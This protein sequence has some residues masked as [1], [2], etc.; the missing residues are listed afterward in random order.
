MILK[1]VFRGRLAKLRQDA[2]FSQRKLA[3]LSGLSREA[4]RLY[5]TEDGPLPSNQSMSKV[6]NCL[7]VEGEQRTMML[8][9][10]VEARKDQRPAEVR[11]YGTGANEE[12]TRAVGTQVQDQLL[13][14]IVSLFHA[15]MSDGVKTA[16]VTA[17]IKT[18]LRRIL[19]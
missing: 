7:G 9:S 16:G 5:E 11:A 15:Y 1:S 12:L 2:G 6:L 10:L 3:E 13:D 17:H 8:T 19:Q 4:I 14:S 18:E